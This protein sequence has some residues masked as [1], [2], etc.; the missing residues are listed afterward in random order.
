MAITVVSWETTPNPNAQKAMLSAGLGVPGRS[1]RTPAEGAGDGLAEAL[2]AVAGVR[3]LL[4]MDTWMTV[5]KA[6]EASWPAVQRGVAAVIRSLGNGG[7][8]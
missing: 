4:I 2:F 8:R 5:N 1:Y 6:P 3:G 7:D